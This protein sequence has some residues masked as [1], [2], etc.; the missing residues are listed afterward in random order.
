M[1]SDYGNVSISLYL[2]KNFQYTAQKLEEKKTVN[3]FYDLS[4]SSCYV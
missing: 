2:I 3:V 1:L 4:D